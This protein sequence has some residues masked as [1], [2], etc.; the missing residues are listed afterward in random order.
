MTL[1]CDTFSDLGFAYCLSRRAVNE[2]FSDEDNKKTYLK[3]IDDAHDHVSKLFKEF[4]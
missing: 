4:V 1:I 3:S 2:G